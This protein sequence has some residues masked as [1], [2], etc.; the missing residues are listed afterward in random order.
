MIANQDHSK[1]TRAGWHYI[2][3]GTANRILYIILTEVTE[4][5][6]R[7]LFSLEIFIG[8][9]LFYLQYLVLKEIP[10]F[11]LTIWS[12]YLRKNFPQIELIL[13]DQ[14]KLN[15]T[16]KVLVDDSYVKP[17]VRYQGN[18]IIVFSHDEPTKAVRTVLAITIAPMTGAPGIC[19]LTNCNIF[20]KTPSFLRTNT[21][22]YHSYSSKRRLCLS[23]D[24]WQSWSES[25]MF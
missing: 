25:S 9:F 7:M 5:P 17:A 14:R 2:V 8:I 3:M 19:L 11:V 20:S 16:F 22:I 18:H 1:N 4:I 12:I 21:E 23:T 24:G 13:E 10:K 15:I 6:P